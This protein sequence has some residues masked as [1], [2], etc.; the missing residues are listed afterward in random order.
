MGEYICVRH[1]SDACNDCV[2]EMQAL[3]AELLQVKSE[4]TQLDIDFLRVK[5]EL[6]RYKTLVNEFIEKAREAKEG[7]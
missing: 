1:G 3:E 7:E 4:F 2:K 6:A 5:T